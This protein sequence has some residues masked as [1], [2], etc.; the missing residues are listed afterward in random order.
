[1]VYSKVFNNILDMGEVSNYGSTVGPKKLLGYDEATGPAVLASEEETRQSV[2]DLFLSAKREVIRR[3]GPLGLELMQENFAGNLSDEEMCAG[4]EDLMDFQEFQKVGREYLENIGILER[5]EGLLVVDIDLL[6]KMTSSALPFGNKVTQQARG[7]R[8]KVS[9]PDDLLL[10]DSRTFRTGREKLAPFAEYYNGD[11]KD[12]LFNVFYDQPVVS[13]E[14]FEIWENE[15]SKLEEKPKA[16]SLFYS[17]DSSVDAFDIQKIKQAEFHLAPWEIRGK[18]SSEYSPFHQNLSASEVAYACLVYH[19]QYG[20]GERDEDGELQVNY[21]D[22]SERRSITQKW[23]Q[24]VYQKD[25]SR[26]RTSGQ[27]IF[28][29]N[30]ALMEGQM[31]NLY[32]PNHPEKALLLPS[33]FRVLANVEN[34]IKFGLRREITHPKGMVMLNDNIRYTLGVHAA[35]KDGVRRFVV[36]ISQDLG[37]ITEIINGEEKLV[38]IFDLLH[39]GD[40]RL[41]ESK[42]TNTT[43]YL[44]GIKDINLRNFYDSAEEVTTRRPDESDEDFQKRSEAFDFASILKAKQ[45]V[46]RETGVSLESLTAKEQQA[47]LSFYREASEEN[48]NRL[49]AFVKKNELRGLKA[50]LAVEYDITV[51]EKILQ[52]GELLPA[53]ESGIVFEKFNSLVA[54][55]EKVESE[56]QEFFF[57]K[58]KVGE[59]RQS[60][61]IGEIMKRAVKLLEDYVADKGRKANKTLV[62]LVM[63]LDKVKEDIILFAAIFKTFASKEKQID[64]ENIRGLDLS[65]VDSSQLTEQERQELRAIFMGNRMEISPEFAE[66]RAREEFDPVMTESGHKFYMLKKDGAVV[67]FARFDELSNGNLYTGFI[68]TATDVRGMKIGEAFLQEVLKKEASGRAVELKVRTEN[69]ATKL[70]QRLGFE[71]VGDTFTDPNTGK[72][73]Y[74]MVRPA[75]TESVDLA[76]AA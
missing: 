72:E 25:F 52:V 11:L 4:F 8:T 19:P 65:S 26:T 22:D 66:H 9:N 75:Q 54:L 41:K 74:H 15:G 53:S 12:F 29:P 67:S 7:L 32:D 3:G 38:K 71:I 37:G 44:V 46:V 10:V 16:K 59:I 23:L 55:A 27:F 57:D 33:D 30:V 39:P 43:V 20:N 76:E 70:Y 51:A 5:R 73:Y 42:V 2:G 36:Q 45:E 60:R 17:P 31:P 35:S 1:M 18:Q 61:V 34:S 6:K 63:E 56:I 64:L 13:K 48:K 58:N 24:R 62:E 49:F 69:P 47:F 50:F 68:N 14:E 40:P 28:S 21:P